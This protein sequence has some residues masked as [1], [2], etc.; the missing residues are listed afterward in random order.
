MIRWDYSHNK[1][2]GPMQCNNYMNFGHGALN[3]HVKPRCVRYR[4]GHSSKQYPL[5]RPNKNKIPLENLICA[6]GNH[7]NCTKRTEYRWWHRNLTYSLK[8]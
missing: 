4:E 2:S 6:T 7:M 1:Q 5:I 8:I 3:C